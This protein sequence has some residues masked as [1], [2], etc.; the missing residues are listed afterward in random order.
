MSVLH[1]SK[2]KL[3]KGRKVKDKLFMFKRKNQKRCNKVSFLIKK[4]CAEMNSYVNTIDHVD[5]E[6]RDMNFLTNNVR[7]GINY[8]ENT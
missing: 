8:I 6:W 1:S 4:A 5:W 7:L 3:N 2:Q